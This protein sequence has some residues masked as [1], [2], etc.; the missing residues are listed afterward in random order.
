VET[1]FKTH[2]FSKG[3]VATEIEPETTDSVVRNTNHYTIEAVI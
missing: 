2:Y 1:Q 3:L